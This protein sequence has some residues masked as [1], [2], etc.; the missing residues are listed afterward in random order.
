MALKQRDSEQKSIK[1]EPAKLSKQGKKKKKKM[2]VVIVPIL[3]AAVIVMAVMIVTKNLFGGRDTVL[4][5]LSSMDPDYET[6]QE[7]ELSLNALEE[8]LSSREESLAKNEAAL[9]E[10]LA[11]LEEKSA[12]IHQ[13]ETNS[14]FELYI[15]GLSEERISQLKQLG[16]IYSNMEAEQAASALSEIGSEMD[17]A[18]VIYYMEPES[19]AE[20]LNCMDSELAAQVTESLLK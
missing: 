16:T 17:M 10:D 12:A 1:Q 7:R 6:A 13:E 19:S 8:E 14:S 18:V 3:V 11:E 15:A 4:S 5:M 2:V 9:A 20:V